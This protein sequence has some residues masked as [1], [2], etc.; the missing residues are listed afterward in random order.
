MRHE[1]VIKELLTI[2]NP[3]EIAVS[4]KTKIK[5]ELLKAGKRNPREIEKEATKRTIEFLQKL[6]KYGV[7]KEEIEYVITLYSKDL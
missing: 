1:E 7:K 6:E 2:L 5:K 4:Y 3:A